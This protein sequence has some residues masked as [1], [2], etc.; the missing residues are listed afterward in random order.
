M[1]HVSRLRWGREGKTSCDLRRAGTRG[2]WCLCNKYQSKWARIPIFVVYLFRRLSSRDL[3]SFTLHHKKRIFKLVNQ[4][5]PWWLSFPPTSWGSILAMQ[6]DIQAGNLTRP[7][8]QALVKSILSQSWYC[9]TFRGSFV[10]KRLLK[11]VLKTIEK[12]S[13]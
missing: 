10:K 8:W 5:V 9:V 13:K 7:P 3:V 12:D 1:I 2:C 11:A 4:K 6:L